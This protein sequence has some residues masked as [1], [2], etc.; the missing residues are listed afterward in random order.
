ME[1]PVPASALIHSA[2]LVSAGIYL[3]LRFNPILGLSL[4]GLYFLAFIGS[5]TAFYGGFVASYQTDIKRILAY[6]TISHCGFL[7]VSCVFCA[8][9]Y[10]I[11]YLYVHGFFKAA[12]FLCVG[13]VIRFCLNYQDIR[14]MGG[15]FKYLPFE[16]CALFICF[17]N[18]AGIPF[19]FGFFIKHLILSTSDFNCFYINYIIYVNLIGGAI[20]GLF[21]CSKIFFNVFFDFKKGKKSFYNNYNFLHSVCFFRAYANNIIKGPVFSC[22]SLGS[23]LSIFLLIIVAY[24]ICFYIYLN[25]DSIFLLS[26]EFNFNSYSISFF[27]FFSINLNE[28]FNFGY[29]NVIII[30]FIFFLVFSAFNKVFFTY[31]NYYNFYVILLFLIL[32]YFFFLIF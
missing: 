2:T 13:N 30:F 18:L 29:F 32:Y 6:S 31:I 21:Y 5:F 3:L 14:Y 23:T 17:L 19:T 1:A 25:L 4:Y 8:P 10:T 12:S 26:S 24:S 16:C 28:F 9:E 27:N 15:F 22:T 7:V 20:T 11:L